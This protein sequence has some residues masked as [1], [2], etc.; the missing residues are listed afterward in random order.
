MEQIDIAGRDL[1]AGPLLGQLLQG[2]L[3]VSLLVSTAR[4]IGSTSG[5]PGGTVVGGRGKGD[6]RRDHQGRGDRFAQRP[7][8]DRAAGHGRIGHGAGAP[9]QG[10]LP[11][12]HR[13]AT[14][15]GKLA[16]RVAAGSIT[17]RSSAD[18]PDYDT[19][20]AARLAAGARLRSGPRGGVPRLLRMTRG[21]GSHSGGG[22]GAGRNGPRVEPRAADTDQLNDMVEEEVE[23]DTYQSCP[24]LQPTDG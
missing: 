8:G 6:M 19:I 22:P 14:N 5:V 7:L 2:T 15:L 9:R 13:G 20:L 23:P 21:G 4:A 18:V 16:A 12:G 3:L 11:R 1:R 10:A 24:T 17:T